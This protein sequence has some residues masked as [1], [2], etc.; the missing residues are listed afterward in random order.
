MLDAAGVAGGGLSVSPAIRLVA[1]DDIWGDMSS[2]ARLGSNGFVSGFASEAAAAAPAG[3]VAFSSVG[4]ATAPRAARNSSL[5][6]SA[7]CSSGSAFRR[8][9]SAW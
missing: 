8:A 2:D 5:R 3:I 4:N 9:S 6:A 1:L 7:S